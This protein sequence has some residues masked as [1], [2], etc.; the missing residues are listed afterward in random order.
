MTA[1]E[2]KAKILAVL[3]EVDHGEEVEITKHGRLVA[4]LVPARGP[5][6]LKGMFA[7]IATSVATDEELFSTGE[8]WDFD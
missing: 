8:E 3:D 5:S 4:R 2:L 7:G 6:A 1:T